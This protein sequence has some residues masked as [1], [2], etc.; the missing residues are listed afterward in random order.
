MFGERLN[1]ARLAVFYSLNQ[2]LTRFKY[3]LH[4]NQIC[5]QYQADLQLNFEQDFAQFVELNAP[6]RYQFVAER[7]P[8]SRP[9]STLVA[10]YPQLSLDDLLT[11]V[12]EDS[13]LFNQHFQQ[14]NLT[15][16]LAIFTF[17]YATY[18]QDKA[19]QNKR[20]IITGDETLSDKVLSKALLQYLQENGFTQA[21][22]A[23]NANWQLIVQQDKAN[24]HVFSITYSNQNKVNAVFE[25][26]PNVLPDMSPQTEAEQINTVKLYLE[27]QDFKLLLVP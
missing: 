15:G 11:Q 23:T 3:S 26:N 20:F 5:A 13:S 25:N 19:Q 9:L 8:V 6:E 7:Q 22:N 21:T 14:E 12:N 2:E 1:T 4:G 16:Q 18:Q 24:K 17:N 27:L 10:V